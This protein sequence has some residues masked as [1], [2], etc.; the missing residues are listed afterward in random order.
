MLINEC[1]DFFFYWHWVSE[2]FALTNPRSAQALDKEFSTSA[3]QV[4][5]WAIKFPWYNG[6]KGLNAPKSVEP[7]TL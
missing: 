3:P 1:L 2:A 7:W 4:I 5:Q 6:H